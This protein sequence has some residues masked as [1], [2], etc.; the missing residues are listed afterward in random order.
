MGRLMC[1][2]EPKFRQAL[3]AAV[4][5]SS[6]GNL[7]PLQDLLAEQQDQKRKVNRNPYSPPEDMAESMAND[8]GE[9]LYEHYQTACELVEAEIQK[10]K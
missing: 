3:A 4:S 5:A 1:E 8:Y 7:Q 6:P 10:M 9:W 2:F